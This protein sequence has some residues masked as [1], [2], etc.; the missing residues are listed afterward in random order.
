MRLMR[1][2]FRQNSEEQEENT[3]AVICPHTVLAPHWDRAEDMPHEDRVSS[4]R[5]QSCGES[6][7]AE[8]GRAL[9]RSEADRLPGHIH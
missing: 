8:E 9:K 2:L 5:C 1:G 7:T 4:Y 3:E 6:F